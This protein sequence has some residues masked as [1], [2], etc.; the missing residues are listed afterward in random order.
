MWDTYKNL[1]ESK[2]ATMVAFEVNVVLLEF[3]SFEKIGE[4]LVFES[5]CFM[6]V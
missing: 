1:Y 3:Y 5:M 6:C 2:Y 4:W